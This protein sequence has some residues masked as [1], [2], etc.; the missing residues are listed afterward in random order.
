MFARVL[1]LFECIFARIDMSEYMSRTGVCS[2]R[3]ALRATFLRAALP[4][5][6]VFGPC[7]RAHGAF[8]SRTT[9]RTATLRA[10]WLCAW[11]FLKPRCRIRG[12]SSSR[13]AAR[14]AHLD[15]PRLCTAS[16]D[17]GVVCVAAAVV[18]AVGG[19]GRMGQTLC[20]LM[21]A[22][23][24]GLAAALAAWPARHQCFAY[25]TR[26]AYDASGRR[27]AQGRC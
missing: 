19:R 26:C 2:K 16:T 27:L 22:D 25:S 15:A 4:Y 1:F 21:S 24:G 18:V 20:C 5:R 3:V 7:C 6:N 17:H 10:S 13:A 12:A 9:L 8:S 11:R 14:A 23:G